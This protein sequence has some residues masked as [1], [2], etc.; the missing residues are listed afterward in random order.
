MNKIK[1]LVDLIIPGAIL[2]IISA[3]IKDINYDIS[4]ILFLFGCIF[5]C[6]PCIHI[7]FVMLKE[8]LESIKRRKQNEL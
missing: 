6:G 4:L 2:V 7:G 8:D 5:V 1:I 3:I